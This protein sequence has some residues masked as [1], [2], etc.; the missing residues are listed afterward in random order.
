MKTKK[1]I[2]E[3]RKLIKFR[4][5]YKNLVDITFYIPC[6]N[7]GNV[8]YQTL[9]KIKKTLIQT[10]FSYEFLIYNDGSTDNSLFEI[11]RFKKDNPNLLINVFNLNK[12]RGLGYNYIDGAHKGIGKYYM[13]ICGDNSE[14]KESLINILAN[15]G[16]AEI[17]IPYFGF[18]D[19]RKL[20]RILLSLCFTKIVNLINGKKIKYYNGVVLHL[21]EN[22]CRYGPSSSGFGYQAELISTLLLQN[23]TYKHVSISNNDRELG[24]SRAFKIKNFFSVAHSLLQILFRRIRSE[25]WPIN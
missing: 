14:T 16:S 19:Q 11:N 21:R 9:F 6:L 3:I 10:G 7:E 15:M 20:H 24:I 17:I 13:M 8:I 5:K 18:G 22:V 4:N 23:M 1:S 2:Y 25:I 12:C